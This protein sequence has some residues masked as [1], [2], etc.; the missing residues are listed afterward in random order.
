[1]RAHDPQRATPSVFEA[2]PCMCLLREMRRLDAILR[3]A[4]MSDIETLNV[5][6]AESDV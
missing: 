4:A 2:I 3:R 1:M 6:A 5:L